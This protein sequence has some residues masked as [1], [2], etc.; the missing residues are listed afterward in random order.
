MIFPGTNRRLE[1][2]QDPN[3]TPN[4]VNVKGL[5]EHATT[6]KRTWFRHSEMV[7]KPGG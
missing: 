2:F 7:V 4:M 3:Q 6:C 1:Y 5:G